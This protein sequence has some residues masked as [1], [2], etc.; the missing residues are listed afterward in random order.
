MSPRYAQYMLSQSGII[1]QNP[2]NTSQWMTLFPTWIQ[3]ML[4]HLERARGGHARK[5]WSINFF[6]QIFYERELE[7]GMC[8]KV[9]QLTQLCYRSLAAT[10]AHSMMGGGNW[11]AHQQWSKMIIVDHDQ[12]CSLIYYFLCSESLCFYLQT[13]AVSSSCHQWPCAFRVF[14]PGLDEYRLPDPTRTRPKLFLK[15]SEFRVLPRK[16]FPS[17][18][19]QIF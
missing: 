16:P 14:L 7:K 10:W 5:S 18:L 9:D 4:A 12:S 8:E 15:I 2:K 19:L 3:E 13:T 11:N 1:W 17:R 6:V